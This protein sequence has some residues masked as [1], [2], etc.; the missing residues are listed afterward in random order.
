M[1][2][3]SIKTTSFERVEVQMKNSNAIQSF[4]TFKENCLDSSPFY[5]HLVSEILQDEDMLD[6]SMNVR[7]GEPV[8]DMF[9][10][11][12]HYVLMR[13]VDHPLALY[14][15]SISDRPKPV[16]EMYPHFVDF[17][18]VYRGELVSLMQRKYVQ[19]NE[20]S[21]SAYLYPVFSSIY[22]DEERPL[23]L[24][25]I[26]TG[27]GLQLFLDSYS[28]SYGDGRKHGK[29]DSNVHIESKLVGEPEKELS[30]ILPKINS[31]IGI[32]LHS[33]DVKKEEDRMWLEAL[34]W[35]EHTERRELFEQA[36][37][38]IH[39]DQVKWIEGDGIDT[40]ESVVS[41]IPENEV[42]VVFH[43][44][45]ANQFS[46]AEK[47]QLLERIETIGSKRPIYH[48]YN[49]IWDRNLH[50]DYV[51]PTSRSARIV[52]TTESHGR[53]FTWEMEKVEH[54]YKSSKEDE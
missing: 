52:G 48:V 54:P 49:N 32:D 38:N 25:E 51:S 5:E 26:G 29:Q 11:A 33:I 4:Q 27:S 36:I 22:S 10:G 8:A 19:T 42:L 9:L 28:Y 39:S 34:I 2:K 24:V 15:P 35:P 13:G 50:L 23:A 17:C 41:R 46:E 18:A 30:F 45:V 6:L 31:R 20:V 1:L 21:R 53:W 16:E 7:S 43:T 44:H 40:L 14:Y 3:M 37:E 12:V 47:D